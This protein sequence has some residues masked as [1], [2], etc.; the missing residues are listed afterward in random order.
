M[1]QQ[2]MI[3]SGGCSVDPE[4]FSSQISKAKS[5]LIIACD[6]GLRHLQ[7]S[8]IK[9]DVIIGDMDSVD[10]AQ[11]ANYNV[12]GIRII[13]YPADK[14]FTDTEMALD[15]ALNLKPKKI[16][17]WCALGG[18]IDHALANILLLLKG[19]EKGVDTFLIDEYCEIFLMNRETCFINDAGKTVSLL[20]LTSEVT[21]ITLSGF[22]YPLENGNLKMGESR[23][24]SNII[25]GTHA[26]IRIKNGKLLVIKYRKNDFFPGAI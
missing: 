14:D 5:F 6:G 8:S 9:P 1:Y 20:A 19:Q 23:G 25:K 16:L 24:I 10:P 17:I 26:G 21:G 4:F 18:R 11:L 7:H 2:I 15:Y 22:L 12:E 3:I 13:Q